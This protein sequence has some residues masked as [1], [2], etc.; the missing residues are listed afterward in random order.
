MEG[1]LFWEAS[2]AKNGPKRAFFGK[3]IAQK[4]CEYQCFCV[5]RLVAMESIIFEFVVFT[6]FYERVFPKHCKYQCF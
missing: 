2:E 6:V 1:S 3:I 5:L 4:H